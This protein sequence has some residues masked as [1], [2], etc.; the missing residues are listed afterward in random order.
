MFNEDKYRILVPNGGLSEET[1]HIVSKQPTDIQ[2]DCV[3][4]VS[5]RDGVQLTVHRAR[6]LPIVQGKPKKA[7]LKCGRVFGV[8]QD[9]VKCPYDEPNSCELL[10]SP[11][12]LAPDQVCAE[13]SL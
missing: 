6:L 10:E 12:C 5:D 13:H 1:F 2:L 3:L 11:D 4:V 9:Q 8:V 7:C